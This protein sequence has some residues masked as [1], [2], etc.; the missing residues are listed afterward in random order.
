MYPPQQ[1]M[2]APQYGYYMRTE[3]E[4]E[5]IFAP[6][7]KLREIELAPLDVWP[8]LRA[9]IKAGAEQCGVKL[10]AAAKDALCE[11]GCQLYDAERPY[12]EVLAG[13]S[14]ELLKTVFA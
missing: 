3:L 10:D 5:L 2:Y 14:R 9:A 4:D 6:P 8:E 12:S 1:P 11:L 7:T 13:V